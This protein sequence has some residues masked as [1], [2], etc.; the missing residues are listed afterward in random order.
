MSL[1]ILVISVEVPKVSISLNERL[2]I[3]ANNADFSFAANPTA[4][5][6][7]KY[8]AVS[9]QVSPTM[10]RTT[11]TIA[12]LTIYGTSLFSIPVS[13]IAAITSGTKSSNKASSI[14]KRGAKIVSFLYVFKYTSNFF[15]L[16][17]SRILSF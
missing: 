8:C 16:F 2:S 14:L 13:I 9:E 1:V 5:F 6:A 7:E 17:F 11:R 10:A 12:I 4:A 3:C 15:I